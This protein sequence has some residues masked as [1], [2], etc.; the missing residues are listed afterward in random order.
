MKL[1]TCVFSAIVILFISFRDEAESKPVELPQ[2][3][4]VSLKK[5]MEIVRRLRRD[6]AAWRRGTSLNQADHKDTDSSDTDSSDSSSSDSSSSDSS[7]SD[8]SSSDSSSSDSSSSDSS[9]SD[10]SSSDSS[11]SDT[12]KDDEKSLNQAEASN[13]QAIPC[14]YVYSLECK[15]NIF[16]AD[17]TE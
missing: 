16:Q 17:K 15:E 1:R 11:S 14:N 5:E 6:M 10:S 7:S 9:S 8:S 4:E 2:E 12:D 13:D 3:G